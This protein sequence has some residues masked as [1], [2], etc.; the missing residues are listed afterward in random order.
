[1]RPQARPLSFADFE[2]QSQGIALEATMQALADT[3]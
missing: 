3:A 1:M 2:L